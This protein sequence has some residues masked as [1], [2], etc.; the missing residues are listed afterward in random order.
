MEDDNTNIITKFYYARHM[1][2]TSK[3]AAIDRRAG[4]PGDSG[5]GREWW[6]VAKARTCWAVLAAACHSPVRIHA[7]SSST[8][9]TQEPAV[10]SDGSSDGNLSQAYIE[11]SPWIQS[12]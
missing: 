1:W 2:G 4:V 12:W 3:N 5:V 7:A 10:T 11:P 8:S 6:Q 9:G